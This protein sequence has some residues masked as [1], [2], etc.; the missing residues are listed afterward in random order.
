MQVFF[1]PESHENSSVL[2]VYDPLSSNYSVSLDERLKHLDDV[3]KD[4][5]KFARDAQ[6]RVSGTFLNPRVAMSFHRSTQPVPRSPYTTDDCCYM[7]HTATHDEVG[8]VVIAL[9]CFTEPRRRALC[10]IYYTSI[11][12]YGL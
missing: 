6:L 8:S 4:L 5:Q 10:L 9:T 12:R 3:S 7:L 1:P 11:C 2:L